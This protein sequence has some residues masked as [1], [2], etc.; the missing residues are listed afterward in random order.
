MAK[1]SDFTPEKP[2]SEEQAEYFKSSGSI[3]GGIGAMQVG[4]GRQPANAE[5]IPV[6]VQAWRELRKGK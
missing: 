3:F 4:Q 2:F 6:L 1:C 5:H